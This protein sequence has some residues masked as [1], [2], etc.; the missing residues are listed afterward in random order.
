M[1]H[2]IKS[3]NDISYIQE[4]VDAPELD[5]I[6]D[7][8][9]SYTNA[10]KYYITKYRPELSYIPEDFEW[11]DKHKY[12]KWSYYHFQPGTEDEVENV[13]LAWKKMY[14]RKNVKMGF[15][16]FSGFIGIDQSIYILTTW[17]EDPQDYHNNLQKASELL[18]DEG[19]SLWDKMINDLQEAEVVEGWFLPQYSYTNGMILTK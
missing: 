19:A 15:R 18:G 12:R 14:E 1:K 11:S 7:Y 2:A 13:I 6:L 5:L 9:K 8:M 10:N 17:A 3:R 4:K 16:I